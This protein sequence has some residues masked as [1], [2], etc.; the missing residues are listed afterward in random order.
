MHRSVSTPIHSWPL[1]R[2]LV[3]QLEVVWID[4]DSATFAFPP[5]LPYLST[6]AAPS[7]VQSK[8]LR[9]GVLYS[10]LLFFTLFQCLG[11]MAVS[12]VT[13]DVWGQPMSC[14]LVS[15]LCN[16]R[17][18]GTVVYIGWTFL[19]LKKLLQR[20]FPG[21]AIWSFSL[22]GS[23]SSALCMWDGHLV[24]SGTRLWN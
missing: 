3:L 11:L 2:D 6:V 7:D 5:C 9:W 18:P 20:P 10:F 4:T 23:F 24:C 12:A 16:S 1:K 22:T 13:L 8:A 21:S 17:D 15:E 14:Q 19:S